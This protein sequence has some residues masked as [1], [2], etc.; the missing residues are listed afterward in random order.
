MIGTFEVTVIVKWETDTVEPKDPEESSVRILR[1]YITPELSSIRNE[2]PADIPDR[3]NTLSFH[4]R[5][6]QRGPLGPGTHVPDTVN[7]RLLRIL[8]NGRT[9]SHEGLYSMENFVGGKVG[10]KSLILGAA[11]GGNKTLTSSVHRDQH[12]GVWSLYHRHRRFLCPIL[13]GTK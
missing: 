2:T 4:F 13:R 7:K 9:V 5:W 1:N 12:H 6:S 10:P 8:R 11:N 3:R